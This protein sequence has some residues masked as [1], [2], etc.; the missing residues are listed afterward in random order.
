V[1]L[2]RLAPEDLAAYRAKRGSVTR[3]TRSLDSERSVY[4]GACQAT[5]LAYESNGQGDF[6]RMA[7]PRIREFL[8]G[9]NQQFYDAVLADFGA[10]RRQTPVLL[11]P[12]LASRSF[13]AP[14]TDA[15]VAPEAPRPPSPVLPVTEL[16]PL[17]AGTRREQA[18]VQVLRG[19]AD[20]IES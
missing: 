13:L 17:A 5:E 2:V 10:A 8:T 4:F 18:I 16:P 6:T 1:R 12:G 14:A 20:L 19:L 9:T 3:A 11:P 7:L 15:P